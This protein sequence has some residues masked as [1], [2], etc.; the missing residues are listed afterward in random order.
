MYFQP[1]M[2]MSKWR[3]NAI[4]LHVQGNSGSVGLLEL[5]PEQSPVELLPG[6]SPAEDELKGA[7]A[8]GGGSVNSSWSSGMPFGIGSA[9]PTHCHEG[10][11]ELH[12]Q[13]RGT[14]VQLGS[15]TRRRRVLSARR[16]PLQRMQFTVAHSSLSWASPRASRLGPGPWRAGDCRGR[17]GSS[18]R[19]RPPSDWPSV[20]GDLHQK[21][22][23]F[24]INRTHAAVWLSG[25]SIN[26]AIVS[27]STP[28]GRPSMTGR[29]GSAAISTLEVSLPN[30]QNYRKVKYLL[31]RQ[32]RRCGPCR[33]S[34]SA[35]CSASSLGSCTGT[36]TSMWPVSILP[37]IL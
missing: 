20:R 24:F 13:G 27:D 9:W 33:R 23:W 14:A 6:M 30:A 5:V 35:C 34:T 26:T 28:S 32:R 16:T 11:T 25:A 22:D 3:Q 29:S 36:C 1:G 18:A 17:C 15:S 21:R 2:L 12:V 4:I 19:S 7:T 10:R 31:S 37:S 8:D